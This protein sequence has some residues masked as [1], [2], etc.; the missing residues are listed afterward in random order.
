MATT[1]ITTTAG[2]DTRLLAAFRDFFAMPSA[3][4]GQVQAAYKDWLVRMTRDVVFNY[5]NREAVRAI[6]PSA[7]FDPS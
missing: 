4:N 3:T 2:Q 1:T 6:A 5:E 7:A